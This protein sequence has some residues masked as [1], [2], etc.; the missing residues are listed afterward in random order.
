MLDVDAVVSSVHGRDGRRELQSCEASRRGT[1][2]LSLGC[3]GN[4]DGGISV[5]ACVG[6]DDVA[7]E[8]GGAVLDF[9]GK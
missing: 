5:V 4:R 9:M 1:L 2:C 6:H 7:V 8:G 3:G